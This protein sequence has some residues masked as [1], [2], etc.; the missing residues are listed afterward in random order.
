MGP[1]QTQYRQC[2]LLACDM[3]PSHQPGPA[4]DSL[5]NPPNPPDPSVGYSLYGHMS[6]PTGRLHR[7]KKESEISLGKQLGCFDNDMTHM[8]VLKL[9]IRIISQSFFSPDGLSPAG[10]KRSNSPWKIDSSFLCQLLELGG[11][12]GNVDS[13]SSLHREKSP[14]SLVKRDELAKSENPVL[15]MEIVQVQSKIVDLES[16]VQT[17]RKHE[18]ACSA[19]RQQGVTLEYPSLHKSPENLDSE[20]FSEPSPLEMCI[21][22]LEMKLQFGFLLSAESVNQ[23]NG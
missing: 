23:Q 6:N 14:A 13:I 22:C 16:V 17:C 10:E 9:T 2:H 1:L 5:D 18:A 3:N 21:N 20:P 8:N 4:A 19:L 11:I 15:S 12:G 7:R